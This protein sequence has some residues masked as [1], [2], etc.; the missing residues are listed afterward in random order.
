MLK[1]KLMLSGLYFL[2]SCSFGWSITLTE[3][4]ELDP[5]SPVINTS[6][7]GFPLPTGAET[8]L[9]YTGIALPWSADPL[10]LSIIIAAGY[11]DITWYHN[12][13]RSPLT[14]D[15]TGEEVTFDCFLL[16]WQLGVLLPL[17]FRIADNEINGFFRYLGEYDDYVIDSA[18]NI[19]QSTVAD[20]ESLI[21][22]SFMTGMI[23]S[24]LAENDEKIVKGIETAVSI[25]WHPDF[26]GDEEKG[27]PSFWRVNL[28]LKA[29]IP[30]LETENAGGMYLAE[31]LIVD[32]LGGNSIPFSESMR[33]GG[34]NP[35]S[36]LGGVLRGFESG[37]YD[38]QFKIA[39]NIEFRWIFPELVFV[40]PIL[41]LFADIGVYSG[42]FGDPVSTPA[43]MLVSIGAGIN[44][45]FSGVIA[46]GVYFAFPV[47]GNAINREPMELGIVFNLHF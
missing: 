25:Q 15:Y 1:K 22:G 7:V 21:S 18:S 36:G 43:G 19:F 6:L 35:Q 34:L 40:R 29:C 32:Y 11:P 8:G 23:Y 39:D 27:N 17:P 41:S 45:D 46:P 3:N 38:T 37:S 16:K 26:P 14:A 10:T 9:K 44:L 2:L 13:D 42:Y 24:C 33:F 12:S 31:N 30:L 28:T 5:F 20:R 47:Q 4:L